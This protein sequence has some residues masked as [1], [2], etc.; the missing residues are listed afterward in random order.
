MENRKITI[1]I[2]DDEDFF[3]SQIKFCCESYLEN[4]C[5]TYQFIIMHSGQEVL[6]YQGDKMDLLF[7]DI[8]LDGVDGI[9]VMQKIL[10][11]NN[12]WRIVFVSSHEEL[13]WDT[14]SVKTLGFERKPVK[15]EKIGKYIQCALSELKKDIVIPFKKSD[16]DT[17][18]K[19]SEI[20]YIE[21]RASYIEVFGKDR[22]IFV[23]GKIG[24]WEEKLKDTTIIRIHKSYLVN[25]QYARYEGQRIK[26][27]EAEIEI[28]VG[29]KYKNMVQEQ[30]TQYAMES[31]RE[32]T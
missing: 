4:I 14:F 27:S 12:V 13:V 23:T 21:G 8:E 15:E 31:M 24:D 1:G 28:P 6:Q 30:Y 26:V 5:D 18:I 7:L 10:Y 17:Y 3:I 16:E 32:R 11:R 2:C 20:Y 29:R 22:N 25:L 9:S 19:L